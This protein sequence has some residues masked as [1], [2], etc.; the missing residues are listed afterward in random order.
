MLVVE[1]ITK[2]FGGLVAVNEASLC[3]PQGRIT[4]LIGPNGAGKTTLFAVIAGFEPPTAGRVLLDGFDISGRY[5]LELPDAL[6]QAIRVSVAGR[7]DDSAGAAT[8]ANVNAGCWR[9][10]MKGVQR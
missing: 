2:R 3:A 9:R 7:E 8:A 5:A 10:L 6:V 4:G 1:R